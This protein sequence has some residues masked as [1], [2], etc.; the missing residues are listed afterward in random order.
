[1]FRDPARHPQRK[2]AVGRIALVFGAVLGGWTAAKD[3]STASAPAPNFLVN[4]GL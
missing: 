3:A 4:A 1:V 2:V